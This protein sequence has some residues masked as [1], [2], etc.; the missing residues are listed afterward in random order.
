MTAE[1]K[2]GI[3]WGTRFK[4][5]SEKKK[6]PKSSTPGGKGGKEDALRRG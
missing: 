3:T 1:K 5:K 4:E 6:R 2:A